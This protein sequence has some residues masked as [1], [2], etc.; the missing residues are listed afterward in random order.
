MAI[1]LNRGEFFGRV[2]TTAQWEPF[3]MSETHYA[4]G[5]FLPW[6]RHEESYLTF[7]LAGGYQ[8]RSMSRTRSCAERSVVLH[9]AGDTHEDDFAERR[10]RCLNVVVGPSFIAR[11]GVAAAPLQRG[12]VVSGAHVTAVA[13]R[14][15]A[16][17]RRSDGATALIV[18]GLLLEMF[19][20]MSRVVPDTGRAPAWLAEAHAIIG[21]RF[22][23][24]IALG[25]IAESVG[26]HP[27]HLARAFRR[28]YGVSVGEHVRALRLEAARAQIAEGTP[29]AMAAA[30]A[31]FSDQSHFT[32]A[33]SRAYGLPP[34]EYRRRLRSA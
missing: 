3:R 15:S 24:K 34:S 30:Q 2:V 13:A 16:E 12:D 17:L 32:K 23:E 14:I 31:G 1:I 9:P 27:A 28:R 6:H 10:T 33:F 11:L 4:R 29:L 7:V 22:A 20:A 8:E 26:V 5:T 25:S 18:E 21:R 19:G